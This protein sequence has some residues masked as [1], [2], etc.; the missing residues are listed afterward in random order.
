MSSVFQRIGIFLILILYLFSGIGKLFD[1]NNTVEKIYQK[2]MFNI[3]PRIISVISIIITI[4]LLTIGSIILIYSHFSKDNL[5]I[6][7]IAFYVNIALILF[8]ILVTFIFHFP[9]SKPQIIHFLK[10]TSIIGGLL[11]SLDSLLR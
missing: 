11:L 2:K 9:D 6:K 8:T 5:L 10:N 4:L 7:N 1:F 3:F